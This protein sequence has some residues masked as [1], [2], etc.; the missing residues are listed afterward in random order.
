MVV[1]ISANSTIRNSNAIRDL[2]TSVIGRYRAA[3]ERFEVHTAMEVAWE[4]VGRANA[5]VEQKAP[6][7]LAKDPTAI[8]VVERGS[9][10]AC[11]N[12]QVVGAH[13]QPGDSG[14][15][16]RKSWINCK[17]D[18]FRILQWGGLPSGHELGKPIPI[19]PR[20]ELPD[21]LKVSQNANP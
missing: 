15:R 9:L 8:R 13:G 18:N 14:N 16:V 12:R 21:D 6:W 19:F 11:R 10:H 20:F 17:P 5:L 4:L 1:S 7:K 2:A 3:F